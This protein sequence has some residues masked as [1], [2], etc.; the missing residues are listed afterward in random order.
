VNFPQLEYATFIPNLPGATYID[1][2]KNF[3]D[4]TIDSADLLRLLPPKEQTS[5]QVSTSY[6]LAGYHYD[7]LLDYYGDLPLEAGQIAKKYY[8][9]L[10]A[11]VTQKIV[12]ANQRRAMQEGLLPYK[13]FLPANVPNSTSV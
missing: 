4:T 2:P 10:A 12:D 8:D 5:T 1:P 7:Q 6:A 9:E 13:Y 3:Q 11:T